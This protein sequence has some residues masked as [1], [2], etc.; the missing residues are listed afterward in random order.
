[1]QIEASY[2]TTKASLP[3]FQP[4]SNQQE[5]WINQSRSKADLPLNQASGKFVTSNRSCVLYR[6]KGGK[7]FCGCRNYRKSNICPF[8]CHFNA[9]IFLSTMEVNVSQCTAKNVIIFIFRAAMKVKLSMILDENR[10][11]SFVSLCS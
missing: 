8:V 10:F 11:V 2:R 9:H 6:S 4:N 1:M 3:M 7:A 5:K